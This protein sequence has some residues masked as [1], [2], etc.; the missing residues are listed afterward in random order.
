MIAGINVLITLLD[1]LAT[2]TLLL[3]SY[4]C[5]L[6]GLGWFIIVTTPNLVL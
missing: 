4:Y 2:P 1:I 6:L 5:Y 3:S